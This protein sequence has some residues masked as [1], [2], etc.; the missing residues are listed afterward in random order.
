VNVFLNMTDD[1]CSDVTWRDQFKASNSPSVKW[2]S[3]FTGDVHLCVC[4]RSS[5]YD[6]PRDYITQ[7][8]T[9]NNSLLHGWKH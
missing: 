9:L 3:S 8:H 2:Q 6:C 4:P 5:C 1:Y 7:Q